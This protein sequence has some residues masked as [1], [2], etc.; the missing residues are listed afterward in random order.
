MKVEENAYP[1]KGKDWERG[2][3]KKMEK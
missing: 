1:K 3:E 2:K